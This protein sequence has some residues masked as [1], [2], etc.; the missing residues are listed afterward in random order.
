MKGEWVVVGKGA[1][2]LETKFP[3]SLS[4]IRNQDPRKI[5]MG[6]ETSTQGMLNM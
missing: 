1:E 6:N 2:R 5:L 3:H 4:H